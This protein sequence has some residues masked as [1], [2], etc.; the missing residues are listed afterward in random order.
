MW[1]LRDKIDKK[2]KMHLWAFGGWA[3]GVEFSAG[4]R[5]ERA[6]SICLDPRRLKAEI[7]SGRTLEVS[8]A[9]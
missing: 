7:A 3:I 1:S 4:A 6:P 9:L 8:S 2:D 5:R